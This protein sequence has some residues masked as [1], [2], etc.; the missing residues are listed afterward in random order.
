MM[1]SLVFFCCRRRRCKGV[2]NAE[3]EKTFPIWASIFF[4]LLLLSFIYHIR[5]HAFTLPRVLFKNSVSGEQPW[6]SHFGICFEP[7]KTES[8][9]VCVCGKQS[10]IIINGL[11][12]YWHPLQHTH[13][14]R[15][16]PFTAAAESIKFI[17][18]HCIFIFLRVNFIC[19]P[20][21]AVSLSLS[22]FLSFS[23]AR[24]LFSEHKGCCNCNTHR[25]RC[26][27]SYKILLMYFGYCECV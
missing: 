8:V 16:K 22:L 6:P 3:T 7:A 20:A 13:R 26:V 17:N 5:T 15:K 10:G 4:P 27:P 18:Y 23:V 21:L 19:P 2:W 14:E 11:Q 25:V 1:I 24:S 9:C 12:L